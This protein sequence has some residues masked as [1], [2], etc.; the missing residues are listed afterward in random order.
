VAIEIARLGGLPL[1][2][3]GIVQDADYFARAVEPHIDG[4]RVTFLGPVNADRKSAL[5]GSARALIHYVSFDEPFGFSVVEAMACGTP[6]IATR[7]GSM[8]ELIR[9]GVNGCLVE[10]ITQAVEA[11]EAVGNLPPESVR[12]SVLTRFSDDRMVDDYVKLYR[13]LLQ[14]RSSETIH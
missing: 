4:Q 8:P 1:V 9:E 2:I 11:M 10:T 3:A 14:A 13:E 12:A 5:L 6:V 7:R